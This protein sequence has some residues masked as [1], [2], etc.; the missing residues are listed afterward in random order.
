MRVKKAAL[1]IM[2]AM[3]PGLASA[4]T[5]PPS[6]APTAQQASQQSQQSQ[7]AVAPG[8]QATQGG[9]TQG[10]QTQGGQTQGGQ[11]QGGQ[12]QGGQTQGGQTQ[13]GQTQGGQ[14]QGGG[15][16]GGGAAGDQ[17]TAPVV[18]ATGYGFGGDKPVQSSAAPAPRRAR[19]R[20]G[21]PVATLPGFEELAEGGSR[22][23]VD[24]SA[25]VPVEERRA[26]GSVTYV[27]KGAQITHHNNTNALV[28]VHFNTPVS[29]ARLVSSG[30]DVLF[31]VDL[32]DAKAQ[33]QYK[34]S[35]KGQGGILTIDFASGDYL[36]NGADAQTDAATDAQGGGG[37]SNANAS[38]GGG[39]SPSQPHA[40]RQSTRPPRNR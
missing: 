11:T 25:Q 32:R 36:G 9:Q 24:L 4:Q 20:A 12:T 17:R 18:P 10:G 19:V 21:A 40:Q 26:Q 28:T 29:R 35:P 14:T 6:P 1:T 5:P 2:G 33:P 37:G 7:Q 31:V 23:F 15:S 38:G 13:G 39:G 16:N 34:M 27:L 8:Q 22:L 3:L 30:N